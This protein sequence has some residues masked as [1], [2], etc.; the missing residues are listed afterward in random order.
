MTVDG[1]TH[2]TR[3]Q[4]GYFAFLEDL[5]DPGVINA[6]KTFKRDFYVITDLLENTPEWLALPDLEHYYE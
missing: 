1:R 4:N 2:T 5:E 3:T 6:A